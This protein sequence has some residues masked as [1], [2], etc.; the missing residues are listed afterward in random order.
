MTQPPTTRLSLLLRLRDPQDAAA[1]N[2]FVR[3]Y[4]PLIYRYG[5][6]HGLQDADAADLTQ[7]VLGA[8][9]K[10]IGRFD[11]DVNRGAFRGWLYTLAHRKRCDFMERRSRQAAGAG[12][13]QVQALLDATPAPQDRDEWD[14]DHRDAIFAWVAERVEPTVSATTWQAFW[15]TAVEGKSGQV[16][17]G[18]LCMTVAAVYL[19]KSRVMVRMKEEARHWDESDT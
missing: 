11:Y 3:L 13:S 6:R 9:N 1:W 7:E 5:R 17:A 16:V 12:D 8:V 4:A 18:E 15:R 14:R 10:S 2:E 19:A